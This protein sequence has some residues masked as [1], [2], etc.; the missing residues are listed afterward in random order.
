MK[1]LTLAAL[2]V[3]MTACGQQNANTGMNFSMTPALDGA[4][5]A[6]NVVNVFAKNADGSKGAY[7]Y[8]EVKTYVVDQ[9][10]LNVAVRAG[11]LGMT[12]NQATV[13]Y[14]DSAGTPFGVPASTF[15]TSAS[16]VIP[17][18]YVCPEE[19]P[20]CSY[21]DKTAQDVT[22]T[23]STDLYLLSEQIA[24]AA[25]DTCIDGSSIVGDSATCSEV[26][27]NITLTGTDSLGNPR[28]IT[29]PQAQVRV[30]VSTVT[31]EVR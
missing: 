27:M 8:S 30:Y 10:N 6:A 25:A 5:V 31:D 12:V 16:I 29:I 2:T 14:T 11:S 22:F 13:K 23:K 19:A 7:L 26:R 1:R 9:G 15:N 18:G 28:S 4:S 21:L 20:S 3:L 24:I 17:S